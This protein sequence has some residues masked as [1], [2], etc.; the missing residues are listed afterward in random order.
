MKENTENLGNKDPDEKREVLKVLPPKVA[1]TMKGGDR[2][3]MRMPWADK[4]WLLLPRKGSIIATDSNG[5]RMAV[6]TEFLTKLSLKEGTERTIYKED[7][8]EKTCSGKEGTCRH[9][10]HCVKLGLARKDGQSV[11]C[12]DFAPM[13]KFEL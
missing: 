10:G 3:V 12:G 8:K 9:L 11:A 6:S 4:G 5:K 2:F 1:V 7:P 13:V